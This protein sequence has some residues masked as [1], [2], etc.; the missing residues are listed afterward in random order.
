MILVLIIINLRLVDG[1]VARHR[2]YRVAVGKQKMHKGRRSLLEVISRLLNQKELHRTLL[3][4]TD[5]QC[6]RQEET[7]TAE[8]LQ[9]IT[10]LHHLSTNVTLALAQKSVPYK[11]IPEIDRTSFPMLFLPVWRTRKYLYAPSLE[12]IFQPA[13]A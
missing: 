1:G 8:E 9:E 7:R 3:V 6:S 2:A 11:S 4:Y 5:T 13:V 12:L 10:S